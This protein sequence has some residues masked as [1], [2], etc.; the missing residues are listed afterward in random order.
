MNKHLP[1]ALRRQLQNLARANGRS[2]TQELTLRLEQTLVLDAVSATRLLAR[3]I[4][5]TRE[6]DALIKQLLCE[7]HAVPRC[8]SAA[9]WRVPSW[10][11]RGTPP[12]MVRGEYDALIDALDARRADLSRTYL[13]LMN[14]VN[15]GLPAPPAVVAVVGA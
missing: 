15:G 7:R 1:S 2:L 14:A 12:D 4:R 6:L 11:D 9:D 8:R 5:Q 13:P 10:L 3:M